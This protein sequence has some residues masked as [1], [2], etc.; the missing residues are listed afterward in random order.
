[1]HTHVLFLQAGL[2]LFFL[3]ETVGYQPPAAFI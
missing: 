1:M 2:F 3:T